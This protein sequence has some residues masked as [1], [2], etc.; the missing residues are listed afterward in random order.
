MEGIVE[1]YSIEKGHGFIK[2][3]DKCRYF[4]HQSEV[5][6][7]YLHLRFLD[8][9]EL[10]EFVPTVD[11]NKRKNKAI[12]IKPQNR[13]D[14]SIPSDY[15]E[16]GTISYVNTDGTGWIKR[17]LPHESIFFTTRDVI[18]FGPVEP[19]VKVVFGF[20]HDNVGRLKAANIEICLPDLDISEYMIYPD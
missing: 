1:S 2:G 8:K 9:N 10:V 3:E 6:P 4:A 19:G 20:Q 11:S 5:E 16:L 18:T 13:P 7:N 14:Q 17:S 12:N 15:W